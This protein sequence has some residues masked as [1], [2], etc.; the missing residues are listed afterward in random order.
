MI[1]THHMRPSPMLHPRKGVATLV[2][3][4]T[5]AVAASAVLLFAQTMLREKRNDTAHF[6]RIQK[7]VIERDMNA[8]HDAA[9]PRP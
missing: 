8:I 4:V 2:A 6:E 7:E 9:E 1:M 3:L 5:L